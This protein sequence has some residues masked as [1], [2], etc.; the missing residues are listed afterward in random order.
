MMTLNELYIV[1]FISVS[2]KDSY[3]V[4]ALFSFMNSDKKKNTSISNIRL[5]FITVFF[6]SSI[7]QG[8]AT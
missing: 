3:E 6:N 7:P 5:A 2:G 4:S 1:D 8:L